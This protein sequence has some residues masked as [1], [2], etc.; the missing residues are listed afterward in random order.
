MSG[1]TPGQP[2]GKRGPNDVTEA[3]GGIVTAK[4]A[5]RGPG[6]APALGLRAGAT[7][8]PAGFYHPAQ[9]LPGSAI[10]YREST[11]AAIT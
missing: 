10:P 9:S 3:A 1:A 11:A 2:R 8:L 6:T 5:P 7:A 4:Q